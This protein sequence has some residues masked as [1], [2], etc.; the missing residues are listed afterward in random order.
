MHHERHILPT[1]SVSNQ[2]IA[3]TLRLWNEIG[4]TDSTTLERIVSGLR[5]Q[6]D[7]RPVGNSVSTIEI[8]APDARQNPVKQMKPGAGG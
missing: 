7:D 8:S 4:C 2:A 1:R 6:T 5:E 3:A